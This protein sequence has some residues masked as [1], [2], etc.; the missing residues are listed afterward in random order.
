GHGR[1]ARGV[2]PV[3]HYQGFHKSLFPLLINKLFP[4]A[5]PGGWG[6]RDNRPL[7]SSWLAP[8]II[9]HQPGLLYTL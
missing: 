8:M 9:L 4:V 6:L 7:F 1:V 2:P 3:E 5:K